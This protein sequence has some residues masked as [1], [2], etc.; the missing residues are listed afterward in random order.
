MLFLQS[1]EFIHI[2][3]EELK[4][5]LKK[6]VKDPFKTNTKY[7]KINILS[8]EVSLLTYF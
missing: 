5:T 6:K 8:F 3:I 2:F 1:I 4:K 7:K